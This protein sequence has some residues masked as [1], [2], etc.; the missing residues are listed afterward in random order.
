MVTVDYTPHDWAAGPPPIPG[1]DDPSD[2][3]LVAAAGDE[4]GDIR[5]LGDSVAAIDKLI[6]A[7][8]R[9]A[10]GVVFTID[11]GERGRDEQ[12]RFARKGYIA[13]GRGANRDR[14]RDAEPVR[15][16]RSSRRRLRRQ[17]RRTNPRRRAEAVMADMG[18]DDDEDADL[19]VDALLRRHQI[20]GAR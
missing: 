10:E 14:G 5:R 6:V 17:T 7:Y 1:V 11:V 3:P 9:P 19:I 20:L 18:T 15:R 2:E 16:R 4:F 12:G 8:R 13:A